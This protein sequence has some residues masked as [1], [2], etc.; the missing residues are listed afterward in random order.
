M[1][2][3]SIVQ[4]LVAIVEE[5]MVKNNASRLISIR[6]KIG[7]MSGIVPEALSTCFEIFTAKSD[8]KGAVLK[9]EIAPLIGCCRKCEE[10]F[11]IIEYDFS[12]PECDS[13]DIDIISGR[14]MNI[15][16]LEVE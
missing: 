15:V 5:E 13:I 11:K 4:N 6:V 2:E 14:E 12:C 3:M 16:E 9:I 1:H 8:L 10:K 7:E